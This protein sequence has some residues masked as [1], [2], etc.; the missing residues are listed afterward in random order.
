MDTMFIYGIPDDQRGQILVDRLLEA[1][2]ARGGAAL[3][4]SHGLIEP[5]VSRVRRMRMELA[6]A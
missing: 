5:T 1:H 4:T 3:I 2:I 6:D